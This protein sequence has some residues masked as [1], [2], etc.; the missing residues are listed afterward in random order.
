[1]VDLRR[2]YTVCTG[3]QDNGSWCGPSSVRSG[4]I[5]AQ[6]WYDVGGGD[7]FYTA[8]DPTDPN[9][10]YSE[11]QNGNIRRGDLSTGE[12]GSIRPRASG[13]RGGRG[14]QPNIAPAP[15]PDTEFRWNWNTP[16][17]L[18]PHNADTVFAGGN[19]LFTSR[20]R[21][22]TWTMSPD[23]TKNIDR[24]E[25]EIMGMYNSVDRCRQNVRG[26][27]CILS[28][29]DGV[30]NWSTIATISESP[31]VPGLLWVGTDD[32]NIQ[33]SRDG[34]ATWSEVSVNLP[35]GTTQYYVSRVEAS[36][37]DPATAYASVDGHRSGDLRPYV[38]VTRDYGATWSSIT[39]DLPP[40]GNVNTIREDPR[41]AQL[42][43]AG[44]EFGFFISLDGGASWHRFMPNLPVVRIDDVLVHPRDNDLV[45][46]THGRSIWIMD[47]V[48]ALQQ[49]DAD[50]LGDDLHL[51]QPRP[52]ILWKSNIR[53][54]RS[55]TGDKNWTGENAPPGTA[56]RYYLFDDAAGTVE[57][58]IT[59]AITGE[60]VRD[61][62]G[63]GNAGLNHVQWNLR[64]NPENEN[65]NQ[66]PPVSPGVFRVTVRANGMEQSGLVE[67]LQDDWLPSAR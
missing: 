37:H 66:G 42:L 61:L 62:Q 25:V 46:A 64:A 34:G 23:L 28:R 59:D 12:I 40:Y 65:A 15:A 1:S 8:I 4:P 22:E 11:S 51:F 16:F 18:S 55:V 26:A 52:A 5:L 39:A 60:V 29:N 31:L 58:Q 63:T 7:G 67:V 2:P 20:D 32:G 35:G 14:G 43:Y 56:I 47:D 41:N 38:Y 24:D 54:D 57:V 48:S 9:V 3:L 50:A 13:G 49:L 30:S 33:V 6:D 45:L 10:F 21:G 27:D 53:R 17:I 19:R 44:T 36:H